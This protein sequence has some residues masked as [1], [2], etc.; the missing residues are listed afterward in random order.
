MDLDAVVV[1]GA[2]LP[3]IATPL[4]YYM[5]IKYSVVLRPSSLCAPQTFEAS[6]HCT[7]LL[8]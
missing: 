1:E 2:V 6:L 4:Q 7:Q 8:D 3:I 5:A